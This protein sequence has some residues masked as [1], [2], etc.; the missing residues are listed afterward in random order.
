MRILVFGALGEV[1]THLTRSFIDRGHVVSPVSS[2]SE[3]VDQSVL[4]FAEAVA[5]VDAGSVDLIINAGGRGDQRAVAR[6]GLESTEALVRARPEHP[7]PAILISTTRVLE[8]HAGLAN[9]SDPGSATSEYGLVNTGSENQWLTL[10]GVKPRVLRLANFFAEPATVDSGQRKLLPWSLVN[11]A[12]ITGEINVRS[13]PSVTRE[14]VDSVDIAAALEL[15]AELIDS[16]PTYIATA[17]GLV[18]DL[19]SICECIGKAFE[20]NALPPPKISFGTEHQAPA[21]VEAR[22]LE[23]MGW[24]CG[25]NVNRVTESIS[26]YLLAR[27]R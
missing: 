4:G 12:L 25:L 23:S 1:G 17:P 13:D 14:F 18:L 10:S 5:L 3:F 19:G 15:M 27:K 20:S 2:R 21:R 26:S 22:W 11:D 6:T 16:C 8:G 7:I 9:E 24:K